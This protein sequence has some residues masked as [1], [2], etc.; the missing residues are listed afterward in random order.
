MPGILLL[1]SLLFSVCGARAA[2]G[3]ED[4]LAACDAAL[5][6]GFKGVAGMLCDW[7]VTPCDCAAGGQSMPKICLSEPVSTETLAKTVVAGLRENPELQGKD[8]ASAAAAVLS[9]VYS[10]PE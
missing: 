10:C 5:T 1:V 4:L 8:A 9:R 2:P 6:N 3:G 7:Y